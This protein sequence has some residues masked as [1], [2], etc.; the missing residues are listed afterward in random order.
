[1]QENDL[2]PADSAVRVGVE[3]SIRLQAFSNRAKGGGGLFVRKLAHCHSDSDDS[4][5]EEIG[6]NYLCVI[7]L[8]FF[9]FFFEFIFFCDPAFLF[10]VLMGGG[11]GV[12]APPC[13]LVT[14][15]VC[16]VLLL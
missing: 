5:N 8:R 13:C 9:V 3:C 7:Q 6:E 2:Y 10:I 4:C 14:K 15:R 1:M 11:R 12:M 16:F